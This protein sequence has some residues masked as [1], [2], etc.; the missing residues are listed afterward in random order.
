MINDLYHNTSQRSLA[1][2]S[3]YPNTMGYDRPLPTQID[4]FGRIFMFANLFHG[5]FDAHQIHHVM[6]FDYGQSSFGIMY[7]LQGILPFVYPPSRSAL[8]FNKIC[9]IRSKF[10][11]TCYSLVPPVANFF[12]ISTP[13]SI[14]RPC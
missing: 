3:M 1:M 11:S 7:M 8:M 2:K 13:W 12:I 10:S 5:L 9:F 6:H 4:A 14:L